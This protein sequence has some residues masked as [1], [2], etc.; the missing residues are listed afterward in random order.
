MN[1]DTPTSQLMAQLSRA[2][3]NPEMAGILRRQMD[4]ILSNG[5]KNAGERSTESSPRSR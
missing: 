1:L 2:Q 4:E 5:A 3:A